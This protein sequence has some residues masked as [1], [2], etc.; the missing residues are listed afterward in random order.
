MYG[1]MVR[2]S[3]VEVVCEREE[4]KF[5]KESAVNGRE[6]HGWWVKGRSIVRKG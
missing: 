2:V 1:V 5:T 3:F 4:V 6:D